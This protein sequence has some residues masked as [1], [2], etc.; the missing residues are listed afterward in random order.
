M[1]DTR[2]SIAVSAERAF[3]RKLAGG[4]HTPLAAHAVWRDGE[5]W[6][7]GL[8]ASRDGATVLRGERTAMVPTAVE[9]EAL[10][11]AL[12]VEFLARGATAILAHT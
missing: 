5:L 7:R 4:C 12:G 2:T 9:A 8:I 6:L 3:G 1:A 11:E 10:G